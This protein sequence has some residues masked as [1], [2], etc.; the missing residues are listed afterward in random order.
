MVGTE[1][2]AVAESCLLACFYLTYFSYTA[3]THLPRDGASR[4]GP[5]LPIS[6]INQ[7]I[8]LQMRS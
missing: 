3:Q 8:A 6:I 5:S 2:E 7:E 1:T 4:S